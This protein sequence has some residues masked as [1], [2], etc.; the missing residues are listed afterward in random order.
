[1][2]VHPFRIVAILVLAPP[3]AVLGQGSGLARAG[4]LAGCWELRAP[5][6][7]TLEMWMPPLGD[8]MPGS[9]RTT[10]GASTSEFE[11]LRIRVEG[12]RLVYT[13][14]PSGQRETSFPSIAI[15]DTLIV[16]ENTAH[17][18]PQRI[19]YRRRGADSIIATIE[20]P[21]P[22]GVRRIPFAYRRATCLTASPPAPPDTVI[23]GADLSPDRRQLLIARGTAPDIDVY[24][25]DANG[26]VVRRLTELP[27]FDY[28]PRW[29]PDGQR[30][31]FAG[32]RGRQQQVFTMRA[33]GSD[34]KE[35]TTGSQNSEPAWSPDGRMIAFRSERDGNPN[36]YVMNADGSGQR[37][38]TTDS[39]PETAPAWS[40]D[41]KQ[42]LYSAT[43]NNHLEVHVVNVDGTGVRQL[44]QTTTGHSRIAFWSPNG[45]QI[46]FGTTRDGNDE[47]YV[48][49]AD[50]TGL[51]NLT[52]H[53]ASDI[54]AGWSSDGSE[55][56]FLS[57][58]DRTARDVYRMKSDG[59][60][61][62][63]VTTTK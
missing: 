25:H 26:Q 21:G 60:G 2:A 47:V 8:L 33:D 55:I 54:P 36:I 61:V 38:V 6:R 16:F 35:L 41:G 12:E 10:V 9:S 1:M 34:V 49:A 46:V 28:Q 39:R 44:T 20:G 17:D 32:V 23:V 52:N 13:A 18:F 48:M 7:V 22:N 37:A 42:L 30:I 57:T 29:S 14:I 27:N 19:S 53:A 4:W 24:L 56:L 59:T 31:A 11:H 5:N 62:T 15:S 3:A 40:P 45:R 58:R 51:R 63:R 43:V 50:G